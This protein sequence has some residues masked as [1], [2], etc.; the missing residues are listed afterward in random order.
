MNYWRHQLRVNRSGFAKDCK[1]LTD[2][3]T[4]TVSSH[5][6]GSLSLFSTSMTSQTERFTED[7]EYLTDPALSGSS[8][9]IFLHVIWPI[10][11][12]KNSDNKQLN[13]YMIC[14]L[15]VFSE[16][17]IPIFYILNKY[18]EYYHVAVMIFILIVFIT[19]NKIYFFYD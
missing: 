7:C 6:S 16:S 19:F 5:S 10:F 14:T 8:L 3:I 18:D 13:I 12:I 2:P 15:F 17:N 1:Y 11:L 9:Y 4:L